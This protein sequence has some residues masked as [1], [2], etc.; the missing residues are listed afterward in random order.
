MG[1]LDFPILYED[2]HLIVAIKPAGV[3]SQADG[4]GAPNMLTLLKAYIK[5]KYNKPGASFLGLV[6]RLDRPA[7]G[8]MVFAKTSKAAMRL[9]ESMRKGQF[10]KAYLCVVQGKPLLKQ[11]R[12]QDF[13]KKDEKALKSFVVDKTESGAKSAELEYAVRDEQEGF[14]LVQV[15]LL[16]GRH[17]QIRVQFA[18]RGFPLAGDH[19]Y[20][21]ARGKS[22]L[23]LFAHSLSFPHPTKKETLTFTAPLPNFYPFNLF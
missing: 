10:D 12:W 7:S 9:S 20:G 1:T 22:D 2:N 15:R 23:A 17:H 18:S 16:T 4:S 11:G 6:H 3:L 8:V 14:S 13:L 19:K 5:E 21:N